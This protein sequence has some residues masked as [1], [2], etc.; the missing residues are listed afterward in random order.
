MIEN[1]Q[2]K[3]LDAIQLACCLSVKRD[4]DHLVTSDGKLAGTALDEGLD[5]INPVEE[6]H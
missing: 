1:H 2:I 3:T 6:D 4:I 5:V